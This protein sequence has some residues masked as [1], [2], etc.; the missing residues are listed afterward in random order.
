[1]TQTHTNTLLRVRLPQ[2]LRWTSLCLR[3]W[4]GSVCLSWLNTSR[5]CPPCP[6]SPSLGSSPSS[7][8]C[9]P[10]TAPSAWSTVSSSMVSKPS[11]SWVWLRW[12]PTLHSSL[13]A[14]TTDRPSWFSQGTSVIQI[15][16]FW[17]WLTA[18]FEWNLNLSQ[19]LYIGKERSLFHTFNKTSIRTLM[20]NSTFTNGVLG[21][22]FLFWEHTKWLLWSVLWSF[23]DQVGSEESSCV[24]S[25]PPAALEASSSSDTD[26]PAV[27]HTNITDLINQSYEVRRTHMWSF[28]PWTYGFLP[29]F[30]EWF[31]DLLTFY[32]HIWSVFVVRNSETWVWGILRGFAADTESKCCRLM[33]T[34]PK[35]T[36]W[37]DRECTC[38]AVKQSD[39]E[40]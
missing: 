38:D 2:E 7:S 27:R 20:P 18:S 23:L 39:C 14:P 33:K 36:L 29:H 37:A 6:L 26:V 34:P 28:W 25:S 8:A 30:M 5:T 1:M 11:S 22:A 17:Y 4:S 15:F 9:C 35:K 19:Q 12:R 24:P 40:N 10:S 32:P 21:V 3:S 13:P 31:Y 16:C